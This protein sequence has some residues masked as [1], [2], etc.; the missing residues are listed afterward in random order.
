LKKKVEIGN[1]GVFRPEMLEPLGIPKGINILGWGLSLE[2]PMM[3]QYKEK[4][5][6]NLVGPDVKIRTVLDNPL[7]LFK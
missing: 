2:R 5:I 3:I 6:R 1:S 4:D 7:C